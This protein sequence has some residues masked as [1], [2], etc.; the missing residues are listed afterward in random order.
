MKKQILLLLTILI[1][2]GSLKAQ[3]S[4]ENKTLNTADQEIIKL[5]KQISG[6]NSTTEDDNKLS[7]WNDELVTKILQYGIKDPDFMQKK[8]P[9]WNN[10][11]IGIFT[12]ADKN[13][14]IVSWNA[15]TSGTLREYNTL[16]FWKSTKG[17]KGEVMNDA[18]NS[19]FSTIEG[20]TKKDG[21]TFYLASGMAHA[22]NRD[23]TDF[24]RALQI[25]GV[26]LNDKYEAFKTPRKKFS[27]IAA[28]IDMGSV[29]TDNDLIH[30][31]KDKNTLL[32]PVVNDQGE[33]KKNYF[34]IYQFDGNDF[35]F[36]KTSYLK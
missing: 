19:S 25:K 12:S 10:T 20:F 28:H 14:R 22:S 16:V 6:Y 11:G 34:L 3:V 7:Q 29:N 35:V 26:V 13:L 27:Q 8:F 1:T 30:F 15:Q 31:G 2:L 9:L 36:Q 17:I 5:S 24:I 18:E 4:K 32:I 21:T 23:K 33:V